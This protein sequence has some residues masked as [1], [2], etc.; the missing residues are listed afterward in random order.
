MG[1]PQGRTGRAPIDPPTVSPDLYDAEYFLGA[2]VGAHEYQAGVSH[3]RY[4]FALDRLDL[5]AGGTLLDV[6]CGRGELL[7]LAAEQGAGRLIGVE[8]AQ[9]AV[10]LAIQHV[11]R[12]GPAAP[13]EIHLA[14][15]RD[16]P[17]EDDSVD[18]VTLMDVIEHLTPTEQEAAVKEARRVLRPG[19][20]LLLHTFPNRRI[21]ESYGAL[22]RFW[23][24]A[25][26]W[27]SD[28]RRPYEHEMHVGE[29]TGAETEALLTR[30]GYHDV[31]VTH[32][33]WT[34]TEFIPTRSARRLFRLIARVPR[35]NA[36]ARASIVGIGRA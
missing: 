10:D 9:A 26:S 19:G 24:G 23:P 33:P 2:A 18:A 14:D 12:V 32:L 35:L 13:C 3:G 8:Y 30:S 6:G 11:E 16:L 20:M 27:P 17:L 21:Y 25:R 7:C 34:Y 5:P 15:A 28:P 36:M 4:W 29:L 31:E 22:R 1:S